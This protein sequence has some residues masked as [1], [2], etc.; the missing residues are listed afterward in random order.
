MNCIDS[1][2]D[3]VS[4][5]RQ[6]LVGVGSKFQAPPLVDELARLLV[7]QSSLLMSCLV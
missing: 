2:P 3:Q 7:G 5:L 1:E 6:I 4:Y